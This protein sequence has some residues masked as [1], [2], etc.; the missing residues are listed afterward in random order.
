MV[1]QL[2]LSRLTL[3]EWRRDVVIQAMERLR[4]RTR[5]AQAA[6][7]G[8]VGGRPPP[9]NAIKV[10]AAKAMLASGT[11]TAFEVTRQVGCS[12]STLYRHVPGTTA[13]AES[14]MR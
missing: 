6:G 9:L 7:C 4:E 2:P 3:A 1:R 12:A 10:R 5:T 13:V 11:M 14:G 8:R